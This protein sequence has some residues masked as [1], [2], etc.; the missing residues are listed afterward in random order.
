MVGKHQLHMFQTPIFWWGGRILKTH[1]KMVYE[2]F[3]H[4]SWVARVYFGKGGTAR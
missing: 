2:E 4:I 3:L 1:E